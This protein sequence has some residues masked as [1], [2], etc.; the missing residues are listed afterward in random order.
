MNILEGCRHTRVQHLVYASSSSVY[1]GNT[2]MPFSE[3][4]SVDHPVSL[5]AATKKANELMAHTYSHLF[6]L[7]TTGL[8]FFTVY[9]PWG[10]PDMALFLFTKAILE[11]R[12]IDVFN[13]GKMQRD[14]TYV[15][16]IVEGVVRVL[17]RSAT[18]DPAYR[19]EAPDPGTSNVPVPR[20]QHRQPQPGA[21]AGL[22]RLHRGRAGHE[23]A[24]EPAAAAGRRRA[25]HL[26][27]RRRAARL[28]RLHAGHRHPHGDRAL[29]ALV[30]GLLQGLKPASG[31]PRRPVTPRCILLP[32]V[33]GHQ[34][35]AGGFAYVWVQPWRQPLGRLGQANPLLL[36]V[37]AVPMHLHTH[38][39]A[40]SGAHPVV[41]LLAAPGPG[42]TIHTADT[43]DRRRDCRP[44]DPAALQLARLPRRHPATE[45]RAQRYTLTAASRSQTLGTITVGLDGPEGLNCDALF[46]EEVHAL[47]AAGLRLCEFTRLAVDA[48]AQSRQV[49]AALFH[50]AYLVAYR[51]GGFDRLL[52]EVH[53]RHVRVYERMFGA[54]VVGAQRHHPGVD[55]PA[56]LLSLDLV[57]V[58]EQLASQAGTPQ[59]AVAEHPFY[60]LAF[61]PQEEARHISRL[62][63][64]GRRRSA[65]LQQF[66][67]ETHRNGVGDAGGV[68]QRRLARAAHQH[69]VDHADDLARVG[70]QDRP[71]AVA[72]VG[73]GVELVDL[74][75][76]L[77]QARHGLASSC[78]A[79]AEGRAM[80]VIEATMPRCVTGE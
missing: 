75:R 66:A 63:A 3:H 52:I 26:R 20:L 74:E 27:R 22:H 11:G 59:Q 8:R 37:H 50:A 15:D 76:P 45:Q 49:L 69:H 21:A 46:A 47:R 31:G 40:P 7:P 13:H 23:G 73:G 38:P 1:G 51:I 18:P 16:D 24:E 64:G 67:H 29:R 35:K 71:A 61:S 17:D 28:G 19:A 70:R 58:E 62:S 39:L 48:A 4:D 42:F 65:A 60:A 32:Q 14:F 34:A 78:R 44:P 68:G 10:R 56:V 6:G 77:A 5:Y 30:S 57:Q 53:P 79:V 25:R 33:C 72:G 43:Q 41:H 36:P 55:A 9:G 54:C 80:V 12:P 2:R